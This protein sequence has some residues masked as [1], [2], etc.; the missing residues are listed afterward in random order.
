MSKAPHTWL[1]LLEWAVLCLAVAA[2]TITEEYHW[3]I[4]AGILLLPVAFGL[5]WARTGKFLPHTGLELPLLIFLGSAGGAT[6]IAV[7][8]LTALL[9]LARMLAAAVMF[10][11]V[12][13]SDK[14]LRPW[15]AAGMV[16]ISVGLAL[17]WPLQHDFSA[18]LGK[19]PS[20]AQT[21][22]WIREQF[23]TI[24]GPFV[25][26]YVA[27]ST[28]APGLAFTAAL[29]A[30]AGK[31]KPWLVGL[32]ATTAILVTLALLLTSS[33]GAWLGVA[34]TGLLTV[35]VFIQRKWFPAKL[36]RRLFWGALLL[37]SLLGLT[38]LILS[39]IWEPL[40][41]QVPDPSGSFQ[42]R[43]SL[44][45]QVW[46]LIGD[47]PFSGFGLMGFRPVYSTYGLLIH[48]PFHYH[49]HNT[50]LEVGFE[51]GL[52]GLF[53]LLWGMAVA[54]GWAWR[55]LERGRGSP[56]GWAGLAVLGVLA[57]HSIFD[58]V[59]Y[60][61]RPLPLIGLFVGMT[62][63]LNEATLQ[64]AS[65][66]R[67][68]ERRW[69]RWLAAAGA[70]IVGVVLLAAFFRPLLGFWNANLG[71]IEQTRL[72][73]TT[74]DA[75][76]FNTP[77]LDEVRQQ[78][79]LSR[80]VGYFEKAL[81]WE[82]ANRT[83]AQRLAQIYLSR[84]EYPQALALMQAAW[85]AGHDDEITRLLLGD[86]LSAQGEPQAAAEMVR[87]LPWAIGRFNTQAWYRYFRQTDYTRATYAWQA[88]LA[89]DP[90]DATALRGLE[91]I[92][93]P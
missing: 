59:Y 36:P 73:L 65:S 41:G 81:R 13:Q 79:D 31:R 30:W 88:V 10:Y 4:T 37:S 85:E 69:R 21:G 75:A 86:A 27:A 45:R 14:R 47:A 74:Y 19:F 49:A 87:G 52:T 93:Q 8:R 83:A 60:V 89:L 57:V 16:M 11:A 1:N 51:Q 28:F 56:W 62:W 84:G 70:G 32:A 44:W 64:G 22:I 58:V 66:P 29:A 26:A 53:A 78:L 46:L 77:T 38:F 23:P 15:L 48:V 6:W 9:Q 24:P 2:F 80:A 61:T 20:I 33:R 25:H 17:Y 76:H 55:A 7:D 39:G 43:L 18:D 12:V 42:S 63:M 90:T 71:V 50:Y 68:S 3:Y 54:L 5:R 34:I 40:L 92:P 91:A 35:M 72:E 82:A 67:S